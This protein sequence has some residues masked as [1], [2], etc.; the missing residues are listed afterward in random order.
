MGFGRDQETAFSLQAGD[1]DAIRSTT[2]IRAMLGRL[3][4]VD[5]TEFKLAR[6]PRKRTVL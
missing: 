1:G 5:K 6:R 2:S 3:W 4:T